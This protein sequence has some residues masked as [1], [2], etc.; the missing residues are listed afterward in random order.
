MKRFLIAGVVLLVV[1]IGVGAYLLTNLD[2]II[3][4][5]VEKVG[6]DVTQVDVR[7]NKVKIG[8]REGTGQ[9]SGLFVGSPAG[10]DE[11]SVFELGDIRLVLDTASLTSDIIVIR[12]IAIVDPVV[13]YELSGKG[14]NVQALQNN[15]SSGESAEEASGAD[16][17]A[18]GKKFVIDRLTIKGGQVNVSSTLSKKTLKAKLADIELR[19]LGKKK[20][21][22]GATEFATLLINVLTKSAVNSVNLLNL[23][24]LTDLSKNAKGI[25]DDTVSDVLGTDLEDVGGAV[26]EGGEKLKSLFKK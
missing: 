13:T 17:E 3:K 6:S 14:S 26:H 25:V 10:F 23:D 18:G 20:G 22:M 2:F 15:V 4:T 11:D 7:L 1:L 16:E 8:L 9:L 12:E 19:D 5:A 24:G 21:G